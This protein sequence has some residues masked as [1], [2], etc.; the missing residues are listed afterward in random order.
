MIDVSLKSLHFRMCILDLN[1]IY[2]FL[3]QSMFLLLVL[4]EFCCA[5]PVFRECRFQSSSRRGRF[6]VS[7]ATIPEASVVSHSSAS[8]STDVVSLSLP[9]NTDT[10]DFTSPTLLIEITDYF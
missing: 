2:F 10:F 1:L 9:S 6:A 8:H 3:F 4:S 5:V 7:E